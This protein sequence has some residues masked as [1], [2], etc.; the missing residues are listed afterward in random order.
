VLFGHLTGRL[1]IQADARSATH[2]GPQVRQAAGVNGEAASLGD[3]DDASRD[4]LIADAKCNRALRLPRL[5]DE[6]AGVKLRE[7]VDD[8]LVGR[9]VFLVVMPALRPSFI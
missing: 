4:E 7:L 3:G 2:H 6:A 1:P 8:L 9:D 5:A